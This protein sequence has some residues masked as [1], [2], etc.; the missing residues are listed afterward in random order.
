MRNPSLSLLS[1]SMLLLGGCAI[2]PDYVRPDTPVPTNFPHAPASPSAPLEEKWWESFGDPQLSAAIAAAL[3]DN[4]DLLTARAG[5]DALLGKFEQAEASLYPQINANTSLTRKSVTNHDSGG[6]MLR[7][8]IT[9]TYAAS[10]SLASYEIDLFGKVRRVNEAARA[11][12]L[13]SEYTHQTVRLSVAAATAASYL[14]LAS[15]QAQI[16]LARDT[17]GSSEEIVRISRLRYRH[18]TIN[19]TARLQAES[20]LENARSALAQL[21]G[22]KIA[23][24]TTHNLLLGRTPTAI[25]VGAFDAI[26]LP[27]VPE[28]L[29][30]E[31][32]RRRPDVASAEANLIAANAQIGIA[33]AQYFPS[34]KLTGMMGVQSLELSNLLSNPAKIWELAPSVSV[35]LFTAGRIEGEI[36]TAQAERDKALYAYQKSLIAALNDTDSALGQR[37]KAIEHAAFQAKRAKALE[38]AYAQA[39]LRYEV[40]TI[41]YGDLLLVQQQWLLARQNLLIARQNTLLAAVSLFKALGG[42]WKK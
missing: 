34:I 27:D 37:A 17:L 11:M 29:P 13:G 21:E 42:G 4:H 35:P 16:D 8:G 32:L 40:G 9:D 36:K 33:K 2:G 23:E 5:V 20:E 30:S 26:R 39:K 24:E 10:L 14:R 7:E 31:L 38:Q 18:G 25:A 3:A 6:Y 1:A 15:L 19:E 28:A 41:A 22:Q 12:L